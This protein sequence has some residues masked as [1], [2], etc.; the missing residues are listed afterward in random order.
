M[1]ERQQR[2]PFRRLTQRWALKLCICLAVA[3]LAPVQVSETVEQQEMFGFVP[4]FKD[5]TVRRP[6]VMV[7]W[8][9]LLA[10]PERG[11]DIPGITSVYVPVLSPDG[12]TATEMLFVCVASYLLLALLPSRC[13]SKEDAKIARDPKSPGTVGSES[14]NEVACPARQIYGRRWFFAASILFCATCVVAT[15]IL[16]D[17]ARIPDPRW[18]RVK[19]GMTVAEIETMVGKPNHPSRDLKEMDRWIVDSLLFNSRLVVYYHDPDQPTVASRVEVT[20]FCKLT[21]SYPVKLECPA[22]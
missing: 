12:R 11:D 18:L 8:R 15:L 7:L 3:A 6:F 19:P 10:S 5:R 9:E 20:R 22:P 2:N 17:W 4:P 1:S 21:G 13:W 14:Q 16:R